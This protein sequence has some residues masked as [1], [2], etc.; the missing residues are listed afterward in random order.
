MLFSCD[1]CRVIT[2]DYCCEMIIILFYCSLDYGASI[3]YIMYGLLC[4]KKDV[5]I[6]ALILIF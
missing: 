3:L 1:N 2:E 6:G 4:K 5:N